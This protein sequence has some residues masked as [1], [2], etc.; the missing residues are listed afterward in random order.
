MKEEFLI[1]GEKKIFL[2]L[3]KNDNYQQCGW[4]DLLSSLLLLIYSQF[5]SIIEGDF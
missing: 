4:W 2:K 5:L 1:L 3:I